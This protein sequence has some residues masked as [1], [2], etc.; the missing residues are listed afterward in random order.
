MST[1]SWLIIML[2]E[3]NAKQSH[4]QAIGVVRSHEFF[5]LS[6]SNVSITSRGGPTLLGWHISIKS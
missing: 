2:Y 5:K 6:A 1:N 4:P 3:S